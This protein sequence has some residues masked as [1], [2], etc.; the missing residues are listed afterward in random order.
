[1]IDA[2]HVLRTKLVLKLHDKQIHEGCAILLKRFMTRSIE[3]KNQIC[4]GIIYL[5]WCEGECW[6]TVFFLIKP[7]RNIT[8]M[9]NYISKMKTINLELT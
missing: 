3:R 7:K 4:I 9:F 6:T 8:L 1:M 2:Y 5:V